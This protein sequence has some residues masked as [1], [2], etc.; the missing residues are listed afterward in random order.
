M[1]VLMDTHFTGYQAHRKFV[2]TYIKAP[3]VKHRIVGNVTL[4]HIAK[5]A[6]VGAGGELHVFD[7]PEYRAIFENVSEPIKNA[8]KNAVQRHGL[9]RTALLSTDTLFLALDELPTDADAIYQAGVP[10]LGFIAGPLYLYD[11]ADTADKVYTQDLVPVAKAFAEIIKTMM[12]TPSSKIGNG[13][14]PGQL[15]G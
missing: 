10:T 6:Q 12:A 13:K 5:Q 2:D 14:K 3:N 15:L 9:T 4:E 8:V 1:F 11:K 7:L